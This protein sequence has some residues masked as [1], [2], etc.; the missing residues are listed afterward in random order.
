MQTLH[1]LACVCLKK[2]YNKPQFKNTNHAWKLKIS[3][4]GFCYTKD[5]DI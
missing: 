4:F 1:H 3:M 2:Q 5:Y